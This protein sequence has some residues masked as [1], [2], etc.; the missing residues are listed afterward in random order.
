MTVATGR[1]KWDGNFDSHS[2]CSV[3]KENET[4]KFA[5]KRRPHNLRLLLILQKSQFDCGTLKTTIAD[6]IKKLEESNTS[7]QRYVAIFVNTRH[8]LIN[9]G[10]TDWTNVL[11]VART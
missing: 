10:R 6:S 8:K 1:R 2:R 9:K 5:A 11:L 4:I 3:S 7:T